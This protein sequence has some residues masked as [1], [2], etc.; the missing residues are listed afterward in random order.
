MLNTTAKIA[1]A[2]MMNRIAVT[3]A[4][5]AALNQARLN[6]LAGRLSRVQVKSST[7]VPTLELAAREMGFLHRSNRRSRP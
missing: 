5:V 6:W 1:S 4:D 7:P 3:T 2:T